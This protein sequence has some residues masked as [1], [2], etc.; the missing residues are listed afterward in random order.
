MTDLTLVQGLVSGGAI[1]NY[2]LASSC[3]VAHVTFTTADVCDAFCK[4]YANGLP[5]KYYGRSY[6]AFVDKSKDVDVISGMLQGFIEAGA[7]RC[8]RATGADEDWGMRALQRLAEGRSRKGKVESILDVYKNAAGVQSLIGDGS[9][10][11]KKIRT[12]VFRF[13]SI[14]DAVQFR[15]M[16]LRE[17]DWEA[18]N[19]QFMDDPCAKATGVHLE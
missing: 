5:F 17:E 19:I 16:L 1:E 15:G 13:T 12:I 2:I 18:S 3:T 4:K 10:T 9:A 6:T 8:V 14:A 7:S 11:P